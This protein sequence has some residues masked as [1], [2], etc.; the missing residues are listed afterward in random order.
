[1]KPF[2]LQ[3]PTHWPESL[4]VL[5]QKAMHEGDAFALKKIQAELGQL[6][7]AL[8]GPEFKL[9]ILRTCTVENIIPS[10]EVAAA[11]LPC[12]LSVSLGDL[13]VIE[14]DLLNA[15]EQVNLTLIFWRLEELLPAFVQ[16]TQSLRLGERRQMVESLEQRILQIKQLIASSASIKSPVFLSTFTQPALIP[17]QRLDS[18]RPWG[19]SYALSYLNRVL[20]ELSST[21]PGL[22]IFDYH[23]FV[24][25]QGVQCFD[26]RMDLYARIPIA[27]DS[28]IP[29]A[30]HI[31]QSLMPLV[32]PR[33][34][35]VAV[36]LDNTLWGGIVGE[37]GTEK[38]KIGLDYPGNIY[39][40]IQQKL[41][42]LKASG[43]LLVLLSKNNLS[44]VRKAFDF[45]DSMPLRLD[46]F[47]AIK[48][49]FLPKCQNLEAVAKELNL[50]L[51]SFAFLDDSDFERE[52]MNYHLPE[53]TTL[54]VS[55]EPIEIL[56]SLY[57]PRLDALKLESEDGQKHEMYV[58]E[59][60][61]QKLAGESGDAEDFLV[62]LAI[63]VELMDVS[64]KELPRV[65]QLLTKTNQ[66]NLTTRRHD[67]TQ[68][69]S[70]LAESRNLIKAIKVSDR[71]GDQGLVGLVIGLMEE[72]ADL[73]LLTIDTLL[74]S[75]RVIGRKIECVLWDSV[76]SYAQ[77]EG[78]Q[79]IRAEYLPTEKNPLVANLYDELG[80]EEMPNSEAKGNS[81]KKASSPCVT[82]NPDQ[83]ASE[84][85]Q[86]KKY[87]LQCSSSQL[88]C[89]E[90][91]KV[92]KK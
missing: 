56:E 30:H 25:Q 58:Q 57:H 24:C 12:R 85:A 75:C 13:E 78:V 6:D 1:M 37:D 72:N 69:R 64:E 66:F 15:S 70:F 74:L 22:Y 44:D 54:N 42:D 2:T 34:K 40:K 73:P 92:I 3:A 10:M 14:Q 38:L 59:K 29:F 39:F 86:T 84:N 91:I 61:R 7:G 87:A 65:L 28:F 41:L 82:G 50:G 23:A 9:R 71:F 5:F 31:A 43:L 46:D 76:V 90:Y 68:L 4:Q 81:T 8:R 67:E 80:M 47:I 11:A 51:S 77:Q 45:H 18:H 62:S 27:R 36:D 19:I 79:E 21:V 83:K 55:A 60:E 26:A 53:V 16:K 89:P 52:Q 32:Q 17:P 35:V 49:D 20:F 63:Q 48:A 88:H 33:L